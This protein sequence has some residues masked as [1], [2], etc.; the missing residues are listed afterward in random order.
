[1]Q[2]ELRYKRLERGRFKLPPIAP[3]T[4]RLMLESPQ[5][6]MLLDG[7]DV[8]RVKKPVR[9]TPPENLV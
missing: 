6:A 9:W 5:L 3:E 1:L 4:E 7:I 2:F 8:S